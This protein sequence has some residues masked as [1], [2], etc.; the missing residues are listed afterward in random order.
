MNQAAVIINNRVGF[1]FF[2]LAVSLAT[3][4]D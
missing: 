1:G 4:M 3:F 2:S